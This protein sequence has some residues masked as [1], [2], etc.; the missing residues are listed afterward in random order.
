[1]SEDKIDREIK[2][3]GAALEVR[4]LLGLTQTEAAKALGCS[5]SHLYHVEKVGFHP[6]L[7]LLNRYRE[8]WG[9]DLYVFAWCRS[10]DV[11]K[12]PAAVQRAATVLTDTW[13]KRLATI[14]MEMRLA[15]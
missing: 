3:G 14:G 8:V 13:R 5:C 11:S 15:K 7:S 4:E 9:I 12:L 6:S 10:G 1:M 2:L